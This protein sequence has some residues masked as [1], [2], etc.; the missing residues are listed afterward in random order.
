MKCLSVQQP[1]AWLLAT[2]RKDI[3]NRTWPTALRGWVLLHAGKKVDREAMVELTRRGL[4]HGT[5]TMALGA[6]VGAMRIDDCVT[7]SASP[8]FSGPYGFVIGRAVILERPMEMPGMLGFFNVPPG[9]PE[10]E[11]QLPAEALEGQT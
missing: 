5:E 8:W 3:E 9:W 6:I 10:L 7:T 11:K 1:W 4:L 2:G